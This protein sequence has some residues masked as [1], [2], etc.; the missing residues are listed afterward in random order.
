M[1]LDGVSVEL[2]KRRVIQFD[3]NALCEI[4]DKLGIDLKDLP[5]VDVNARTLR[6]LLWAGLLS[7][8]P[9]ITLETAGHL[10]SDNGLQETI[11]KVGEAMQK[12]F[13][14]SAEGNLTKSP[15]ETGT[16]KKRRS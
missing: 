14:R 9:D 2:D 12:A 3:L 4:E 10:A 11:A 6:V 13:T 15:K 7:D 5:E 16:G 1:A 8:D